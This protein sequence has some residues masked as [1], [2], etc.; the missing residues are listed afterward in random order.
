MFKTFI[1]K[2]ITDIISKVKG[3]YLT[4]NICYCP[5]FMWKN[6]LFI[7]NIYTVCRYTNT[8]MVIVL[9]LVLT[10]LEE[11]NKNDLKI[12]KFRGNASTACSLIS[13]YN[14]I[15]NLFVIY[16][17][18]N[19][20]IKNCYHCICNTSLNIYQSFNNQIFD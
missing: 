17:Q 14:H 7:Y 20:T 8:L 16:R 3:D 4:N 5:T 13:N 10:C 15:F 12:K 2:R 6:N 18:E 9:Y 11:E 19:G 1:F